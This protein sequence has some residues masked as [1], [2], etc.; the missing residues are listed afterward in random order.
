MFSHEKP[1][2]TA[3]GSVPPSTIATSDNV[4]AAAVAPSPNATSPS[5]LLALQRRIGNAAVARTL[6]GQQPVQRSA[7]H[8]VLRK[9]GQPL[10]AS[11]RTE[12]E[13]RLGADFSDVRLH[14][15][16]SAQD[17]ATE[18][19]A[20]AYT[21]GNH[22]VIGPGGAD[23]HTLAH[24]LT[25]V[26]QQR[27]GAVDG[28]DNGAGLQLSDPTDR[29]E[30]E[31]EENASRALSAGPPV[32]PHTAVASEQ[33]TGQPHVQRVIMPKSDN[34]DNVL[35]PMPPEQVPRL[36]QVRGSS[37]DRIERLKALA[38]S[39]D[40]FLSIEEALEQ[41]RNTVV[42]AISGPHPNE[43]DFLAN[44]QDWRKQGFSAYDPSMMEKPLRDRLEKRGVPADVSILRQASITEFGTHV[45]HTDVL[46]PHPGPW[47]LQAAPNDLA[48]C[49]ERVLGSDSHAYVLTD[50]EPTASYADTLEQRIT[51]INEA[52][53]GVDG[54]QRLTVA[55]E[56]VPIGNRGSTRLGANAEGQAGATFKTN[57]PGEYRLVKISRN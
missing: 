53:A 21:S 16:T 17:S 12:M 8:D 20:R 51:A 44:V 18:I 9:P 46:V 1:D 10:D 48:S 49:L 14:T 2:E 52:N 40:E 34:G 50:S 42:G 45:P 55:V 5:D 41:S 26:I 47:I 36:P 56:V 7:V 31:A 3:A 15:D 30:R 43:G 19:G 35:E 24:E 23:A 29:F 37:P 39:E 54:Y 13:A 22:V 32:H 57:H 27:R 33:A 28:T 25:H 6:D 38:M 11:T 4:S